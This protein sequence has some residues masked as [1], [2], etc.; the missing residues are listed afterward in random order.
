[1]REPSYR[2]IRSSRHE[3]RHLPPPCQPPP[4]HLANSSWVQESNR[5]WVDTGQILGGDWVDTGQILGGDWVDTGQ[6]LGGDWVDTGQIL[7]GD[8]VD[9]GQILSG[10]LV[11]TGQTL[12]RH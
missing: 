9:T 1:M 3:Y 11:D 2:V 10:D 4:V 8:W 7:G 6:I 12:G 5:P